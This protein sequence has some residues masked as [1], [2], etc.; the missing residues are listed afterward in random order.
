MFQLAGRLIPPIR[1][2]QSPAHRSLVCRYGGFPPT[3]PARALFRGFCGEGRHRHLLPRGT[4][5]HPGA[6]SPLLQPCLAGPD[7][8][9]QH[10][11][12]GRPGA[13]WVQ[14]PGDGQRVPLR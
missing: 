14:R 8:G 13:L 11:A 1:G 3:H 9:D 10:V 12:G 4:R 7:A 6:E 5:Q 2:P